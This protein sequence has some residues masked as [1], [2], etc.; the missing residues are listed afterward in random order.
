MNYFFLAAN[1][2]VG[3]SFLLLIS[4]P[5]GK[6]QLSVQFDID[7]V[8]GELYWASNER[9]EIL[10]FGDVAIDLKGFLVNWVYSI[11]QRVLNCLLE[12]YLEIIF[13]E[14]VD[15]FQVLSKPDQN[16]PD[17]RL[18]QHFVVQLKYA[19]LEHEANLQKFHN[20]HDRYFTVIF[21][22]WKLVFGV[23]GFDIEAIGDIAFEEVV[24]V[25][26]DIGQYDWLF[27]WSDLKVID[28]GLRHGHSGIA[29]VYV[30]EQK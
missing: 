7:L 10:Q 17:N 12:D 1:I 22:F 24:V 9:V 11:N 19:M 25:A 8:T 29:L 28:K 3:H 15:D 21:D 30:V 18:Y 5:H 14:N 2:A 20:F 16:R 26:D 23:E 27:I 13:Q 4:L 6:L